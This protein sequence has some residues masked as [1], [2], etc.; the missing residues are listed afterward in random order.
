MCHISARPVGSTDWAP[1]LRDW[2]TYMQ[3]ARG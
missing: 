1:S 3:G 2:E